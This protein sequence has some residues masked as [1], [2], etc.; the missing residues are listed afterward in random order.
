MRFTR[1]FFV[2]AS[3]GL[4]WGCSSSAEAVNTVSSSGEPATAAG[5]EKI[6]GAAVTPTPVGIGKQPRDKTM[7]ETPPGPPPP[8]QFRQAAEDSEIATT[9]NA[10]GEVV[11]TRVFKNHPQIVRAEAVWKTA[12]EATLRLTLK[13]GKTIDVKTDRITSLQAATTR[14]LMGIAGVQ[15]QTRRMERTQNEKVR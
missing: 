6:T 13:G 5:T 7:V 2:I 1:V 8:L 10:Q 12:K 4:C 9:M 3:L 14:D 15:A 11:E